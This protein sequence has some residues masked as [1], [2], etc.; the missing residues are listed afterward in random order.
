[1]GAEDYENFS[2][3]YASVKIV[4]KTIASEKGIILA[5]LSMPGSLLAYGTRSNAESFTDG[6]LGRN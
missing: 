6:L 4:T 1:M 3:E 5:F 2:D